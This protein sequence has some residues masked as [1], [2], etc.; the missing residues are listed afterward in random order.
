MGC[1]LMKT[2]DGRCPEHGRIARDC[3]LAGALDPRYA[4][5]QGRNQLTQLLYELWIRYVHD[6]TPGRVVP[7]RR[8]A[9]QTSPQL[10][11]RQ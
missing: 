2:A 1:Q 10:R 8:E 5:I 4:A 7:R 6:L 11:H 3:G 9:F